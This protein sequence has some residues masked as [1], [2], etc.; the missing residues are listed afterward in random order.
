VDKDK[1]AVMS[2]KVKAQMLGEDGVTLDY[3]DQLTDK[4][5]TLYAEGPNKDGV[6]VFF[7]GFEYGPWHWR[8]EW[9]KLSLGSGG[10]V[11]QKSDKE[12]GRS[13]TAQ[14]ATMSRQLSPQ[15]G[16]NEQS[17]LEVRRV[18]PA[19]TEGLRHSLLVPTSISRKRSE[20]VL[21]FVN[22]TCVQILRTDILADNQ[23]PLPAKTAPNGTNNRLSCESTTTTN[24][25]PRSRGTESTATAYTEQG[26]RDSKASARMTTVYPDHQERPKTKLRNSKNL[27]PGY[28]TP[29]ISFEETTSSTP[30][31]T[32][33]LEHQ[34]Q[35]PNSA[36]PMYM[37][38]RVQEHNGDELD[39]G[40][41]KTRNTATSQPE[42][43]SITPRLS[44]RHKT[45][46][47]SLRKPS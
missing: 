31:A 23:Q 14:Q 29:G 16:L 26:S 35:Y 5:W 40:K 19:S 17:P 4:D 41:S 2:A 12:E 21:R 37:N 39:Y 24:S 25:N 44:L 46:S 33:Y 32:A 3:T 47:P 42:S 13:L 28:Q 18:D 20:D 9:V 7:D 15:T 10:P 38:S 36:E 45:S 6:V 34:G 43:S 30:T 27:E 22:S 11:K 8:W 1:E